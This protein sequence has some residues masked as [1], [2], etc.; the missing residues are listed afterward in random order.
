MLSK[1]WL[2][3]V[4]DWHDRQQQLGTRGIFGPCLVKHAAFFPPALSLL[5]NIKDYVL[6]KLDKS[7]VESEKSGNP[8]RFVVLDLSPVSDVD[9][10]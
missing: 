6:A 8:V 5:Q 1:S 10:T 2:Q 9:A 7:K 4:G 3:Q